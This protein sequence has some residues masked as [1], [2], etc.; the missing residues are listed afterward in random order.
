MLSPPIFSVTFPGLDWE[1]CDEGNGGEFIPRRYSTVIFW[2]RSP[3]RSS[4]SMR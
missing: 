4:C 3:V 1:V 2:P